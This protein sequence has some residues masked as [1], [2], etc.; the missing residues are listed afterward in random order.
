MGVEKVIDH[1][2]F[3]FRHTFFTGF[4]LAETVEDFEEEDADDAFGED[5][6]GGALENALEEA[7]LEEELP[8]THDP[9]LTRPEAHPFTFFAMRGAILEPPG[10]DGIGRGP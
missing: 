1:L 3:P 5:F 7:A 6:F 9:A 4:F 2:H 8:L 10:R